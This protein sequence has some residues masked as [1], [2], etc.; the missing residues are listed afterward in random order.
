MFSFI[1]KNYIIM[2][3]RSRLITQHT[4]IALTYEIK[5]A[6]SRRV[7][8]IMVSVFIVVCGVVLVVCNHI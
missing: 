8:E 7:G 3:Q 4:V 1:N 6:G 5:A 2:L